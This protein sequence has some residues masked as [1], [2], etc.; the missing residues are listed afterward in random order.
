MA[1]YGNTINGY[2]RVY[3]N[4]SVNNNYSA[5]TSAITFNYGIHWVKDVKG[6]DASTNYMCTNDTTSVACTGQTTK[7]FKP[8]KTLTQNNAYKG[9]HYKYGS[10]TF[11][12]PKK[13][14]AQNII[15]TAKITH[16]PKT[17][18]T[19]KGT[20]TKAV[21]VSVSALPVYTISFNKGTDEEV[22]NMPASVKKTHGVTIT[23]PTNE[24]VREGYKFQDW[25]NG[26]A[27]SPTYYPAGAKYSANITETML[28]RWG[29][30]DPPTCKW[31]DPVFD[32]DGIPQ[33]AQ[34]IIRGFT[35]VSVDISDI[36]VSH[37]RNLV[38][39]K[40]KIG[41]YEAVM[42]GNN[43]ITMDGAVFSDAY[44]NTTQTIYIVTEDDNMDGDTPLH[45][46]GNY[47][48]GEVNIIP[49][50]WDKNVVFNVPY[51]P[52]TDA[53]GNV[54]LDKLEVWNYITGEYEEVD[55]N[56]LLL[57][58]DSQVPE[59]MW[60][61]YYV[62]DENHVDPPTS[63][64]P[65]IDVKVE[66]KHY[67][68]QVSASS[69]AFYTTARNQNYSN[70]IY[71]S[72]FVGGVDAERFP[73]FTSRSWWCAINNPLYFPDTNYIEV[74]SNDTGIQGLTKVGD[75]LAVIKQSKT[76]DTAIFLLYPT[77]FEEETT[78]A[79]KQG[80]QGVGAL[81]KYSFNILG[82]ETL[83]LSP[84][85]VMAI[86]PSQDDEH[87]VQNRSYF[88]DKK[89]LAEDSIKDAY[90][91]VFDGKYYLGLPNGHVYVLD[92]N[93]RNS[94]GNDR[95]NLVYECY[96][97]ENVPANCF[98]KFNDT[99]VFSNEDCVCN[100]ATDYTDAYNVIN[101]EETNVPV[102]AEWSTLLDDD[103]AL[104]YYK[105]MQKKGNVVSVLPIENELPYR[106]VQ[107]EEDDFDEDRGNYYELVDGKYVKCTA[108]S[109]YNAIFLETSLDEVAFNDNKEDYY[110]L[111]GDEYVQCTEESVFDADTTYYIRTAYYYVENRSNT[112]V[113]VKRDDKEPV[114]IQRH[115][116]LNSDIPSEMYLRKKF[117]KYKRLQ[118]ILKNE[119]AEDFGV[120]CI[121]KNYTLGNYAKR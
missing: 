21:T 57:L 111:V 22:T 117:K 49:P 42:D 4:Y 69:Q 64:D 87:K 62:F 3:L 97:L 39:V 91:F 41:E 25:R 58:E 120:D 70:G 38:S 31:T 17:Y 6:N 96:Y 35:D 107:V 40:M 13:T 113:Y 101:E 47:E 56:N 104:H 112:K 8:N 14:T 119:E 59:G 10:G 89:L 77:S 80:V 83:F 27:V 2:W 53:R 82:D 73:D 51:K 15:L 71:N 109:V 7:T 68:S 116:G 93:Q 29:G 1:V 46:I 72:M 43:H 105:T 24:P 95:T 110:T 86:T 67:D 9:L 92:G 74:G 103:G 115:F 23:L 28:A 66:Y 78:Y 118:F 85:G 94:W 63:T 61:F 108:D 20:S 114:E 55:A 88:V 30:A 36:E 33:T 100:F 121:I 54:I 102:K 52:D 16:T 60:G 37:G 98:V 34:Q 81:A 65:Q 32:V 84:K 26:N 45:A 75:Y 48:V 76:T 12:I 50:S 99:L 11:Y 79:V 19:Y 18:K 44:D 106:Q 5:T 90:S